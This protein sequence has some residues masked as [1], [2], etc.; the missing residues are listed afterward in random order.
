[1]A[2]VLSTNMCPEGSGPI[3]Q[4][5][6]VCPPNSQGNATA[7]WVPQDTLQL[8]GAESNFSIPAETLGASNSSM[9]TGTL[10]ASNSSIPAGTSGASN[11]SIPAGTFVASNSSK[12]TGTFVASNSSKS[13]GTVNASNSSKSAGTVNAS[14]SFLGH[15][16][17]GLAALTQTVAITGVNLKSILNSAASY[18]P[19][20]SFNT[21]LAVLA[22]LTA[23]VALKGTYNWLTKPKPKTTIDGIEF[24]TTKV[25]NVMTTRDLKQDST[26]PEQ[27]WA[28]YILSNLSTISTGDI[29]TLNLTE[30]Q[31]QKIDETMK[32]FEDQMNT[33]FRAML[34]SKPIETLKPSTDT[35]KGKTG[36]ETKETETEETEDPFTHPENFEADKALLFFIKTGQPDDKPLSNYLYENSDTLRKHFNMN[37]DTLNWMQLLSLGGLFNRYIKGNLD[38]INF[39]ELDA[40]NKKRHSVIINKLQRAVQAYNQQV[41]RTVANEQ[42]SLVDNHGGRVDFSANPKAVFGPPRSAQDA[43][44][45][46]IDLG[47]LGDAYICGLGN[48]NN[49]K[50]MLLPSCLQR[51][52]YDQLF[53][54]SVA[55]LQ[56]KNKDRSKVNMSHVFLM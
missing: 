47:V 19:S 18:L 51:F 49:K 40:E 39:D 48:T 42:V 5:D 16:A 53:K 8:D 12:S 46:S 29:K 54:E 35:E 23:L 37:N 44:L 27:L 52:A 43:D 14:S 3:P 4:P 15:Y 34:K 25:A 36:S 24:D 28:K 21:G 32:K 11:S 7:G 30:E 55:R 10:G 33:K 45:G 31:K 17:A 50:W 2:E 20:A 13:A 1:M 56:L 9:L 41:K 22:G 6:G 26:E 38:E